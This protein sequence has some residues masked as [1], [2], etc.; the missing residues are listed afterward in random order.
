[1]IAGNWN[2]D[3]KTKDGWKTKE[4][5]VRRTQAKRARI[6]HLANENKVEAHELTAS[7]LGDTTI[8]VR[9]GW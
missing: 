4:G 6:N 1:M 5:F 3:I 7:Q 2:L 8:L 9:K